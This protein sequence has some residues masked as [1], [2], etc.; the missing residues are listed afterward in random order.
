M[1][2]TI[3]VRDKKVWQDTKMFARNENQSIS[4]TIEDALRFYLSWQ[5]YI[6]QRKD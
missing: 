6:K 4:K 2:K 3:Y 5:S 1:N